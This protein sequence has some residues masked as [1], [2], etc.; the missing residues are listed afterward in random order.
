MPGCVDAVC[1]NALIGSTLFALID[2]SEICTEVEQIT[3]GFSPVVI[4]QKEKKWNEN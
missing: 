2:P 4:P 3:L 1:Q